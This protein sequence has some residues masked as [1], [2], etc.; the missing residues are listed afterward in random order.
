[1]NLIFFFYV[2]ITLRMRVKALLVSLYQ[3][4]NPH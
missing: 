2:M 3:C 1:M 4:L